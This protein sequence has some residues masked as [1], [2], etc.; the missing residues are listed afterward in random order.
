MHKKSHNAPHQQ[1]AQKQ[2][3]TF[4]SWEQHF[5]S[6]SDS[7]LLFRSQLQSRIE[8]PDSL[9]LNS[10]WELVEDL[11]SLRA[12]AKP[13]CIIF[14]PHTLIPLHKHI[15]RTVSLQSICTN[16]EIYAINK[17]LLCAFFSSHTNTLNCLLTVAISAEAK[18]ANPLASFLETEVESLGAS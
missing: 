4:S 3:K 12:R 14:H 13:L 1:C 2:S 11:T 10:T 9:H 16:L 18:E 8:M 17:I 5:R 6:A 15:F 7:L